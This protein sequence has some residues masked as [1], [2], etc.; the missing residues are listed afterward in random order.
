MVAFDG[1]DGA[2]TDGARPTPLRVQG[3]AHAGSAN[4]EETPVLRRRTAMT[5]LALLAISSAP[6]LAQTGGPAA[7]PAA[8]RAAPGPSV[9]AAT[10]LIRRASARTEAAREG[11]VLP[12]GL[13]AGRPAAVRRFD[14]TLDDAI[15]RALDRNLNI[16]VER[17]NPQVFDLDLAE[18]NAFYRPTLSLNYD[19]SSA[20]SPSS[21]QLDGGLFVETDNSNVDVGVNQPVKWGGGTLNVGFDNNRRETTNAFTSF[22][23]SFRSVF[24]AQYVQPLL[25]GRSID[26]NRQQIEVT[27]INQNISDINLRET[28]TNTVA[29]VR[30]AYWELLYSVASVQVQ[31]QALDLAEQLVQDNRARV[32]IG[33]LAP[34]DVVQARSEAATRRQTLAQAQQTLRTAE[35]TLK[36]LI[37]DGTQ[38]DLWSAEINPVD[39]PELNMPAIDIEA[40]VR[41][42]LAQRTD[43]E[44]AQRQQDINELNVDTLTNNTLP[45][46]DL[47]GTYQLQGQGG[48]FLIRG[49]DLGG[50]VGAIIPG[51]YSDAIDQIVDAQ[52]PVWS[53][54]VQLSY[55]LGNSAEA[56]ALE[57]ARLQVRQTDAQL[58][59]IEL[60]VATE[61]TNAALQV[62]SIQ[63]RIDAAVAAR[64]LA[65]EQL[66]AEESK[67]EV[68]MSTNFFVVQAQRD[69]ATAQDAELRAILD[70]QRALI[71]LDRVQRTSLAR[72]GISIV[73]GGGG[74]GA[75][76]AG[77]AGGIGIGGGGGPGGF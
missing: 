5:A 18:Q 46:L 23:P 38:D 3:A 34:I 69:L 76:G 9:D 37:V 31:Q 55:P 7:D 6:A 45:A 75:P 17:I 20:T 4:L 42:A 52:F 24:Q 68:G 58:R 35:L 26:F 61:V 57:R 48:N 70:Y 13:Q 60:D 56:A 33:T 10:E 71:E 22:N 54:G 44:R 27:L 67:F 64:E 28:I 65:Q 1:R 29:D 30:N 47:V 51:G 77:G 25:R 41:S 32:E 74:G 15:Q 12:P 14:L 59:Q 8:H 72:A 16:A 11:F 73:S 62:M 2:E 63:E 39:Q 66:S 43:L 50:E 53:V 21:F 40:A 19:T 36:R 49:G